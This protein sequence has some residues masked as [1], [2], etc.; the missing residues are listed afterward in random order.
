MK[1]DNQLSD[2]Q[3][4]EYANEHLQYEV[5]MLVWS[6]GILAFLARHMRE[7]YLPWAINNGLLNSFALHARNLINFLYS[8]SIGKDYPTDIVLEDYISDE[9]TLEHLHEKTP[10]LE[11]AL[12]KSNKQVAHLSMERIQYEQEGKEWKFIEL[13]KQILKAFS[14][15]APHVPSSRM[16]ND[17]RKKLAQSEFRIPVVDIAI[18][19]ST[20]GEPISVGFSLRISQ[21]GKEIKSVSA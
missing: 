1:F 3:L 20:I 6:A 18:G 5:D 10:L 19:K 14:S 15:I 17:L 12:I 21:D 9:A 8:R 2:K 7:G 16:G 4:L 11:E 13:S